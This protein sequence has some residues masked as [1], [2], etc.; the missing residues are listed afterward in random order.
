M[1]SRAIAAQQGRIRMRRRDAP[2]G[3]PPDGDGLDRRTFMIGAG[4][5]LAVA[6]LSAIAQ[7]SDAQ[8]PAE[9][10]AFG[11][12]D[13][14]DRARALAG[15]Q[16]RR[17]K[18]ELVSPF[19]DLSAEDYRQIRYRRDV[20]VFGDPDVPFQVDLL[21]PNGR[22]NDRVDVA[23]VGRDGGVKP[24]R[25]SADMFEFG[26]AFGFAD[27]R[28]PA[29]A[30]EGLSYSG[31]RLLYPLNGPGSLDAFAKFQ[32]ASH[33]R[34]IGRN[35]SYGLS[36]RGLT[37]ATAEPQGE[38]FPYFRQFWLVEPAAGAPNVQVM[39][40][41]DSVS[42]TGAYHFDIRP[43]ETTVM[44]VR[45]KLFPRRPIDKI[46]VAPLA[47]MY[48]FG[49]NSRTGFDD[50]RNAAHDSA[51]LQMVHGSGRRLLRPLANPSRVRISA[52]QDENP[53]G[54]GLVQRR[55]DFQ[56]YQDAEARFER[57]PSG[58]I[59][60][61]G[62]WGEGQVL[63][64]EIPTETDRN[65]NVVAF[66]RPRGTLEPTDTG[67][68]FDYRLHWCA[69]APDAAPLARVV[70][71]RG[72]R[73]V[74]SSDRRVFVVDFALGEMRPVDVKPALWASGGDVKTPQTTLLPGGEILRTSFEF[75]PEGETLLEF[76]LA[77]EGPEGQISETWMNQW[78]AP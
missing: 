48:F 28:A 43:G 72:G 3:A 69:E 47:S 52:F 27:G 34:A 37:I 45:C 71:T 23:V 74:G 12:E 1:L 2:A 44:D 13:V 62:D 59:E 11:F 5:T 24:A 6:P 68:A 31:F 57:R 18:L 19:R 77:L 67:H 64:V 7:T 75:E 38:E 63:L 21:A 58:W 26:P 17:D 60:P 16:F 29:G 78:T 36:A 30:A 55:R 54:F 4:A 15:Q 14:I 70:A 76:T 22:L 20:P 41:L 53:K 9:P 25:F 40:L 56:Y 51:A 33:F 42:V 61:I 66:W 10:A 73:V 65:D 50:Y 32:G 46:G 8:A 49:P 35:L 39:A